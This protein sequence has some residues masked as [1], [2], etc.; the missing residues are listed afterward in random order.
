P[1]IGEALKW[2]EKAAR[3]GLAVAQY[4][5]GTFYQDGVGV[6][7]DDDRALYWFRKAIGNYEGTTDYAEDL[8]QRYQELE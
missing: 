1:D 8:L 3:Q 6:S 4:T 2:V 5:L 7:I